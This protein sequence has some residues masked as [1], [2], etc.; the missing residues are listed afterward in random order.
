M[1]KFLL[2]QLRARARRSV[3]L[4]AGI[5]VAS[6]AFVLL[7]SAVET[8]ALQVQGT[9]DDAYQT[10]YDILVRPEGSFADLER[11]RGLIRENYLSG[12]FGGITLQDYEQ[13]EA[14]DGVDVAA[15]IANV[16]YITPTAHIPTAINDL[17]TDDPAQLYRVS[18]SW[19][20][21]RGQSSYDGTTAYIYYTDA[22]PF[23]VSPE[24][25]IRQETS[26]DEEGLDV[27]GMFPAALQRPDGPFDTSEQSSASLSCFS[28]L[29]PEAAGFLSILP[30]EDGTVFAAVAGYFPLLLSAVDPVA[31]ARLV[32]LDEAIVDG[33]YL[34]QGETAQVEP[35]DAIFDVVNIPVLA[36]TQVYVDQD[37]GIDVERLQIPENTDVA[38]TLASP[39]AFDFVTGLDGEVI[40]QRT[41]GG[42]QIYTGLIEDF[43]EGLDRGFTLNGYW[44]SGTVEYTEGTA[45]FVPQEVS[46]PDSV[47]ENE[48]IGA[49]TVNVAND[50]VGFREL[51]GHPFVGSMVIE[52]NV[53]PLP[54]LRVVGQYDP[55][56]LGGFNPLS[57]VPLETYYPPEVEGADD[58]SREA[59]GDAPLLPS[60][61]LAGYI[62][63]PPL[64]LTT[65]EAAEQLF[66]D[67]RFGGARSEA[68]ISVVRV[69][70]AEVTGADPESLERVRRVAAEIV[71]QTGL[72]VD[73]TA[74]SS[75]QPLTIALPAGDYGRPELLV[76][77]GWVQKGVAV[78]VLTAVDRKSLTL[79]LLVLAVTGVF[80]ANGTMASVRSRR[81]ELGV[82][83]CL[84]WSGRKVF[85]VVLGEIALVGGAAGLVGTGIAVLLVNLLALDVPRLYPLLVTP[86]AVGLALLAG[87][88]PARRAAAAVPLEAVRP[89]VADRARAGSGGGVAAMAL[90]NLVRMPSRALAGMIGLFAGVAALAVLLGVNLAFQGEVMGTLLGTFI[91]FEVRT[92]DLI[93]VGCAIALGGLSVGDVVFLSIKQRAPEL[94]TLRA[95]GWRERHL[96]RLIGWEGLGMGVVASVAG[97]VFGLGVT[98]ATAGLTAGLASAAAAA[99]AA[100]VAVSLVVTAVPTALV[101]RMIPRHAMAEE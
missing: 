24:R 73:I 50:D 27:C 64:M 18:Y 35:L 31:E 98:A 8:S 82:L 37:L 62:A 101:G 66:D 11:D 72:A 63:Q 76:E 19:T 81:R 15:P 87:V 70:V 60:M 20:A 92:V 75:P 26:G 80:L 61:N 46:N 97:G 90:T 12:I 33:R 4:G 45:G 57:Q 71:E 40:E 41:V 68:P 55:E 93:A 17:L 9:V 94:A 77:E 100:G 14:I 83:R 56:R 95:I 2:G 36:T 42:D 29:S 7:V 39:G 38:E 44:S 25:G 49:A 96:A 5:V 28:A 74:G 10:S 54:E 43:V 22:A 16:G 3:T 34:E 65:L 47:W 6:V 86:V 53:T 32:G 58:A 79:F 48:S 59:L 67:E 51:D 84:G 99:V 91:A 52:D 23:D 21:D 88:V 89:L 30:V 69:R 85:T 13:I 78:Q 1:S